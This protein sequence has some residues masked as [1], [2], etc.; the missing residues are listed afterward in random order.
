MSSSSAH[1]QTAA[2]GPLQTFWPHRCHCHHHYTQAGSVLG[3]AI[4]AEARHVRTQT[5]RHPW[6]TFSSHGV[7]WTRLHACGVFS[8]FA[9]NINCGRHGRV[10]NKIGVAIYYLLCVLEACHRLWAVAR[11]SVLNHF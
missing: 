3:A 2:W 5:P 9:I 4:K 6:A 1:T 10:G 11:S 7:H 8:H